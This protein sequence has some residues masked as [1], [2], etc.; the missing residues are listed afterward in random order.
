MVQRRQPGLFVALHYG[1]DG[2]VYKTNVGIAVDVAEFA[3]PLIIAT[4]QGLD[5]E[6]ARIDVV[7]K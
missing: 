3:D 2:C 7:E 6:A 4:N 5:L 1:K